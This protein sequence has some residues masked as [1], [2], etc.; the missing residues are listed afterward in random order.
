M[1]QKRIADEITSVAGIASGIGRYAQSCGIDV[2]PICKT[3]DIDPTVF[4]SLTERVSLDRV[5]RLLETCALLADDDSFGLKCA[6]SF[7]AGSTGPFGYG[8]LSA[9][10]VRDF[11]R[12]LEDHAY[13]VTNTSDVT[14]QADG[15]YTR[16]SWTFAP[17]IA[18][19]D[20]YVDMSVALLMQRLRPMIAKD[21]DLLEIELERP[22]PRNLQIFRDLLVKRIE[23]SGRRNMLRF[24]NQML[25]MENP[26]AD[27]RLFQL[28]DLQC[29]VLRPDTSADEGQ[30]LGQVRRYMQMRVSQD[31]ISLSDIAPYF[32]LSERTFQ[33]RL[34]ECG[35]SLNEVRDDVRKA[36][37]FKLL[38]DSDLPIS[39]I[40]YRLGYSAPSAFSRS[41]TRW[42]GHTPRELREKNTQNF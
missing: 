28:M 29:R 33:R 37:S 4:Q 13:Y 36:V 41:V 14:L 26:K 25:D 17:V 35:T 42:F 39:D 40:A 16:L 31:E 23:F 8:L 38:T 34:A 22:R 6:A 2:G 12:F 18:K 19:R 10:T 3:L 7:E 15:K 9:P 1:S 5:C 20:Q 21:M 30:F 24:P 27:R 11:I 32:S